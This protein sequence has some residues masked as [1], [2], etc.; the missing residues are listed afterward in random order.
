MPIVDPSSAIIAKART[1][2]GRR[3]T[4]KDYSALVKC[5]RVGDVVRYLK[6]YTYYQH[7]LRSV[8]TDI[9]RGNLE[10]ILRRESFNSFLSLC[11]YQYG[12]SVV[13]GFILRR[14]EINEIV[15]FCTLLAIG[16][17]KEYIFT[18]PLY[19]IEHTNLPLDR[20]IEVSDYRG[21]LEILERHPYHKVLKQ[22][23]PEKGAKPDISAIDDAL[24]IYSL[25]ELYKD[26]N[27]LKNKSQKA[28]LIK[29]F[30]TLC[31]YQNYSRIMRMKRFYHMGND[32]LRRHLIPFGY[33]SGRR[34]DTYLVDE[35][36][37]D[38]RSALADTSV[39]RRAHMIDI[40]EEMASKG[41]FDKCRHELY[42]S[43]DPEIVLL[44][45]YIVSETELKNIITVIEGVR[46]S[47]EP[48]SIAQ[49][50][51]LSE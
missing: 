29:L 51:I 16:R 6:S 2:Y 25:L 3:L 30:D 24:D 28:A 38:I 44:S 10:N 15:K 36:Y 32:E 13:T 18:M 50:L 7:Y 19:F 21:L 40:D 11:R 26:I 4:P 34:L 43:T 12:N 5:E 23:L 22:F 42:F 39:G 48:K 8:G 27:D 1:K 17:P 45:Y 46:Y 33:L 37:E 20:F 49:M 31:D 35:S 47:M 9:H 14:T 41:R